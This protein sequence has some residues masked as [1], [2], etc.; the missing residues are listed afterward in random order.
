MLVELAT[1]VF[2]GEINI[3]SWVCRIVT[4]QYPEIIAVPV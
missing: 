3:S 4:S 1:R 2:E